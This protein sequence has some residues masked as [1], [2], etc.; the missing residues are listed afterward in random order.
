MLCWRRTRSGLTD[1]LVFT[2]L[3]GMQK[4]CFWSSTQDLNEI[5]RL[6]GLAYVLSLVVVQCVLFPSAQVF[7]HSQIRILAA[8]IGNC[9]YIRRV[10]F[11]Y[12]IAFPSTSLLL[13]FRVVALYKNNKYAIAFFALCW[14][15][16]LALSIVVPMG[17][18]GMQIENT[19]YCVLL[20]FKPY[21]IIGAITPA[22]HDTLI[23]VA[24]TLVFV[25]NSYMGTNMKNSYN[26]IVLGR[27][28]PAFSKS[29]LRDSDGQFYFL[30]LLS[31][32]HER[33]TTLTLSFPRA[34]IIFNIFFVAMYL[35][36]QL[37][38]TPCTFT[39]PTFVLINTMSC[40]L[41]R[42]VRLGLYK[43]HTVNTEG[44]QG[45][46]E[47]SS[48][49]G[50]QHPIGIA[51]LPRRSLHGTHITQDIDLEAA[52]DDSNFSSRERVDAVGSDKAVPGNSK[53][54]ITEKVEVEDTNAATH[55]PV[56][57]LRR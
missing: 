24:T 43:D 42:N 12:T 5:N 15:A 36:P 28:L 41:Y 49:S 23:F 27:N 21:A 2:L 29:L 25:K 19:P 52:R 11:L 37:F 34:T 35:I 51:F 3:Q 48:S 38:V 6:S 20:N 40:H 32:S 33:F 57:V 9:D 10:S 55:C 14:L 46:L 54:S 1:H 47:G 22:V 4:F 16:V 26:I 8:P 13:V 39:L 7:Y 18:S 50:Q 30:W 53:E 44:L 45:A 56:N 31:Y 17:A